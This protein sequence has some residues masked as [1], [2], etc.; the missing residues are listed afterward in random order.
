MFRVETYINPVTFYSS[1]TV[2]KDALHL[3]SIPVLAMH[4]KDNA[5]KVNSKLR[6]NIF[7]YHHFYDG[8]YHKWQNN[9]QQLDMKQTLK[10]ILRT[11]GRFK[12]H[13]E[14]LLKQI[15]S[16]C[17]L[18][19]YW[20]TLGLT[21]IKEDDHTSSLE[22]QKIKLFRAFLQDPHIAVLVEDLQK[23]LES[24][25][26]GKRLAYKVN[27]KKQYVE[28]DYY[29]GIRKIYI[30]AM[31]NIDPMRYSFFRRLEEAGYEVIFRIPYDSQY[32]KVY[33]GWERV[34]SKIVP[35]HKW[36]VIQEDRTVSNMLT[37][38]EGKDDLGQQSRTVSIHSYSEPTQFKQYLIQH[39]L[40]KKRLELIACQEDQ[41]NEY[42]RDVLDE[43]KEVEHIFETSIGRFIKNM[44]KVRV[45]ENQIKLDFEVYRQLITSGVINIIPQKGREISGFEA[46]SL[47]DDLES[48]M[49]DVQTLDE[50]KSRLEK[51]KTLVMI[52]NQFDEL[53][54]SKVDDHH[55]KR[56]LQNPLRAFGFL[57]NQGYDITINQLS[58]LTQI[59][60]EHIDVFHTVYPPLGETLRTHK[61]KFVQLIINS[62]AYRERPEH[63]A[64]IYNHFLENFA[65]LKV[66]IQD[67]EDIND[68]IA[69]I[70]KVQ[71]EKHQE[72][73]LVLIK[74]IEHAVGLC[75]NG[76]EELFLCDLSTSAMNS[77]IHQT[78]DRVE[79]KTLD[80]IAHHVEA[81]EEGALKEQLKEALQ[82]ASSVKWHMQSF[83]KFHIMT[84]LTYY[85]GKLHLGWIKNMY[86]HDSEWYLLSI[87][88]Q[89]YSVEEQ[90][91]EEDQWD[92]FEQLE[93][94]QKDI[95]SKEVVARLAK[96]LSPFA[97]QEFE[98]C[99]K[100]FYYSNIL[101][102]YPVYNEDFTQRIVF[103]QIGKFFEDQ[104]D[105]KAQVK[106]QFFPLFPQWT[107]TLKENLI[108]TTPYIK[109][110]DYISFDNI[111][112]PKAM[113]SIWNLGLRSKDVPNEA[114]RQDM[115]SEV[116][117]K[118]GT[119]PI[120][121]TPSK[122]C[123][124]CPHQFICKEGAFGIDGTY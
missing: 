37:F 47:L 13:K 43:E 114:T 55:V 83:V 80:R 52:S 82:I 101:S 75:V 26:I 22:R 28:E 27:R 78:L 25:V 86:T 62:I 91:Q 54:R 33:E 42:F 19:R 15:D 12:T 66:H 103:G 123:Y 96:D 112:L 113:G 35:F 53:A 32:P 18:Y 105:G 84:L 21:A 2:E 65:R 119:N 117:R 24:E 89:L 49:E 121:A 116:F 70:G 90:Q 44:Y 76:V 46:V 14:I 73:K 111:K 118:E 108:A 81:L 97:W 77:Y 29:D 58:T 124:F 100:K 85:P 88:K 63:L 31:T 3:I 9:K 4:L 120:E 40:D 17:K 10:H 110:N 16:L 7:I 41:L 57:N 59:L 92:V 74:G 38:L 6:W 39:P 79:Y 61:E 99:K 68:Y 122:K 87:I 30:Y 102:Y 20:I 98:L 104:L 23:P 109:I 11:D 5:N 67:I 69:Y 48:Y 115:L 56:Y 8:I 107:D 71:S 93:V 94:P 1:L 50:I 36:E 34:Y 45:E 60:E 64:K 95:L 106:Q 51:L 72:G